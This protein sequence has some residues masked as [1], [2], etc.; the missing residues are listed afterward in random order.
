MAAPEASALMSWVWLWL[1]GPLPSESR[2]LERICE[3]FGTFFV[4]TRCASGRVVYGMTG[5]SM[6]GWRRGKTTRSG[7]KKNARC[8]FAPPSPP[9]QILKPTCKKQKHAGL[10]T[11]PSHAHAHACALQPRH[12]LHAHTP[13]RTVALASHVHMIV[14]YKP[15]MYTHTRTCTAAQVLQAHSH[16]RTPQPRYRTHTNTH[17][18]T[19]TNIT[20]GLTRT[21]T[22]AS[23]LH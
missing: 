20:P 21:D 12:S 8:H 17:S 9:Q 14:H 15:R 23:A 5:I 11:H 16:V 18:H 10:G 4:V 1:T 13:I 22:H 7:K 6:Y 19:H 3:Q 2:S